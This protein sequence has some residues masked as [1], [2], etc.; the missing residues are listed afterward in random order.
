M[1]VPHS[2]HPTLRPEAAGPPDLCDVEVV[3]GE[4]VA[5]VLERRAP[6]G[7]LA[8]LA[9]LFQLLANPARLRI[10][11]A[12]AHRELCVCDLAAVVGVSQSA[13]SHH[14]RQLRQMRIVRFRKSGRMAYYRL[15]D[16]HIAALYATGLEHV[17]E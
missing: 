8:H 12:L 7:E 1:S 2:E 17:R 11:E 14:L 3:H 16:H 6:D 13:V 5:E 9:D 15:D 4:A 10:V